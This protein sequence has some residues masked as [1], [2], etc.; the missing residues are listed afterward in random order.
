MDNLFVFLF[1]KLT[2]FLT[3]PI[4]LLGTS[5]EQISAVP[6]IYCRLNAPVDQHENDLFKKN[7]WVWNVYHPIFWRLYLYTYLLVLV[8]AKILATCFSLGLSAML[9]RRGRRGGIGGDGELRE[10]ENAEQE[11]GKGRA[12]PA[13]TQWKQRVQANVYSATT[14]HSLT[15]TIHGNIQ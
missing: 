8:G 5:R 2:M 7:Y 9:V 4:S 1:I 12:V 10:R 13:R 3:C 6:D 15:G 11:G 14:S